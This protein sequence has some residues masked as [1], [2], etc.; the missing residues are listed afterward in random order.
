MYKMS[1]T[2]PLPIGFNASSELKESKS[3][4]DS[5]N[6]RPTLTVKLHDLLLEFHK[7]RFAVISGISKDFHYIKIRKTIKST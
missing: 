7:H 1:V 2:T 6:T 4:N 3:L 5:L